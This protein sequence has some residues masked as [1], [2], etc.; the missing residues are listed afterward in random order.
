[1]RGPALAIHKRDGTG[2]VA[3]TRAAAIAK[4]AAAAAAAGLIA[5]VLAECGRFGRAAAPRAIV[6]TMHVFVLTV[7]P[8]C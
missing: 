1:M 5:V 3:R 4:A 2:R 8:T 7:T 6:R